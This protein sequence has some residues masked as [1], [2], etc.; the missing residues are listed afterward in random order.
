[1]QCPHPPQRLTGETRLHLGQEMLVTSFESGDALGLYRHVG[2]EMRATVTL[3][4]LVNARGRIVRAASDLP[5]PSLSRGIE[6]F[7]F[8]FFLQTPG[9]YRDEI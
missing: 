6:A 7:I 2:V 5:S 8:I 4:Q 9:I 1:M 3:R